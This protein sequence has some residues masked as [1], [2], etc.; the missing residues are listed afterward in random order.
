[1]RKYELP[2]FM[3]KMATHEAYVRWLRRRAQAHVKRDRRRGNKKAIGESY[4]DAIH[5]AVLASNGL[6]AYTGEEL[7]WRLISQFD[8]ADAKEHGR[9]YKRRFALQ[10]TVDHV[11]DGKGKPN[12]KICGWRTN[13]VKNDLTVA[14]LVS[15]CRAFLTYQ[16]STVDEGG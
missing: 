4:R 8:N 5:K 1:V 11:G 12:F 3:A 2:A 9:S 16:G 13:A 15:V 6:D 14:E 7:N 10:P